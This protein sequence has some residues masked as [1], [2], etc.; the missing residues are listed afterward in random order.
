MSQFLIDVFENR[1]EA[2]DKGFLVS[3]DPSSIFAIREISCLDA[4]LGALVAQ[5]PFTHPG[6]ATVIESRLNSIAKS[7]H[8]G[9]GLALPPGALRMMSI[10]AGF[11]ASALPR[12]VFRLD[13]D[14]LIL[15]NG[16]EYDLR[17]AF[18][19]PRDQI[20][21]RHLTH[22]A[23]KT[24]HPFSAIYHQ[25]PSGCDPRDL[26]CGSVL[27][28]FLSGL[29]P[30]S[31]SHLGSELA[32][33][34]GLLAA[35]LRPDRLSLQDGRI[36]S[37]LILDM[38][39]GLGALGANRPW[40]PDRYDEGPAFAGLRGAADAELFRQ[41]VRLSGTASPYL[42]RLGPH[43]LLVALLLDLGEDPKAH[44]VTAVV[45]NVSA[46][47]ELAARAAARDMLSAVSPT[48]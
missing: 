2:P 26:V 37:E 32:G 3:L 43:R 36:H 44:S 1:G 33:I 31:A 21:R 19:P 7:G 16:I 15:P 48:G 46:H 40:M 17:V 30:V 12:I 18:M 10:P 42:N 24:S 25:E 38:Q 35:R 5:P 6:T 23:P 39:H 4:L 27:T 22:A 41:G 45:G 13:Q 47:S 11:D 9:P 34:S 28:G 29:L 8:D 20:P 14:L